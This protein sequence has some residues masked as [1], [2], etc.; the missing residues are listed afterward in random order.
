MYRGLLLIIVVLFMSAC[1]TTHYTYRGKP[2]PQ[3][4]RSFDNRVMQAFS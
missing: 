1:G 2:L 3:G 4:N